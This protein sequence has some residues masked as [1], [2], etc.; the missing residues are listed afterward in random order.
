MSEKTSLDCSVGKKPSCSSQ[1]SH[2]CGLV[3]QT[4]KQAKTNKQANKNKYLNTIHKYMVKKTTN[5]KTHT[6]ICVA[7]ASYYDIP[8][9][10]VCY[11]L[12]RV[13]MFLNTQH[14]CACITQ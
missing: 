6:A 11:I 12:V 9:E 14:I 5:K 10:S 2:L 1:H 8:D 3:K 13:Q 4:N 7:E